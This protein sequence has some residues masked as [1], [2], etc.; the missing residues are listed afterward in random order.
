MNILKQW[1]SIL[2]VII[3]I[4][5]FLIITSIFDIVISS[6]FIRFYFNLTFIVIFGVGGIFDGL[7]SY[8][9][10]IKKAHEKN[11]SAKRTVI[12]TIIFCGLLFFFILS[13]QDKEYEPAFKAYGIALALTTLFS[14]KDKIE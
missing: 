4:I 7:F 13:G 2:T 10:G 6:I 9:Y 8:S 14:A 12:A 5:I 3:V 11:N 1:R